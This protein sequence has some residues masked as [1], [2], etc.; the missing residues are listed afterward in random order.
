MKQPSPVGKRRKV[1]H[2]PSPGSAPGLV[3]ESTSTHMV[4]HQSGARPGL[5][6]GGAAVPRASSLSFGL[7]NRC[8]S[9]A[10]KIN[11]YDRL[12]VH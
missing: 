12:T 2:L 6:T 10:T 7:V 4:E 11:V 1:T 5:G 9:G 8:Y 3:K